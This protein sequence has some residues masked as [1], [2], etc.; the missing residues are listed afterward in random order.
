V[1]VACRSAV[2]KM[3]H[4]G[5]PIAVPRRAELPSPASSAV[6]VRTAIV[7]MPPDCPHSFVDSTL[8]V[9]VYPQFCRCYTSA[10]VVSVRTPSHPERSPQCSH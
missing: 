10:C 6:P 2:L 9:Y 1:S 5:A 4:A 3:G 8:P 7:Q